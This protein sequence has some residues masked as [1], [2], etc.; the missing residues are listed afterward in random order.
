M[1]GARGSSTGRS[2]LTVVG[3]RKRR[4]FS[5]ERDD[6]SESPALSKDDL[7]GWAKTLYWVT[8]PFIIGFMLAAAW[9]MAKAGWRLASWLLGH[10]S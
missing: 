7:P 5:P 3:F 10:I 2:P 8:A 1:S 4:P 9:W 6:S